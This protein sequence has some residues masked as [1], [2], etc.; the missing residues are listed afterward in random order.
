MQLAVQ[1]ISPLG[2]GGL[3]LG[4]DD[5]IIL[6]NELSIKPPLCKIDDLELLDWLS[7]FGRLNKY[8]LFTK[9]FILQRVPEEVRIR[10]RLGLDDLA[11]LLE[12]L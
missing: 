5:T 9:R 8:P 10:G 6:N 4:L 7:H 3:G 1:S 11:S 12:P 2:L